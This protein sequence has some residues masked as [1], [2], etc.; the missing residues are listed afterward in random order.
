[1]TEERKQSLFLEYI[2]GTLDAE[3]MEE[4]HA[5]TEEDPSAKEEL[6]S[7]K[8]LADAAMKGDEM[9][10]FEKDRRAA[11]LIRTVTGGRTL[12]GMRA[13]EIFRYAAV[14]VVAAFLGISGAVI[15]RRPG[16]D[17]MTVVETL[18]GAATSVTLPDGTSVTLKS[19]SVLQYAPSAFDRRER[20]VMLDGEAFFKVVADPEHPF[21]VRTP[22]Q[23][24]KVL[25][26]TFNVQDFKED[27]LSTIILME[28]K[29]SLDLLDTEGA[30]VRSLEIHP[31][32]KCIY[33]KTTGRMKVEKISRGEAAQDWNSSICYFRGESLDRIASRLEQY[34]KVTIEVDPGLG[35][36]GGYSGAVSLGEGVERI[37]NLLNYDNSFKLV[38]PEDGYYL[39]KATE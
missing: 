37:L 21:I 34:F 36:E 2:D 3:G 6:F 39:L 1:M 13:R 12:A 7:L 11:D 15:L 30:S 16:N 4:L 28:G 22:H 25:G 17:S 32:E 33:D 5:L 35:K 19:A 8:E 27:S 14:A 29:V 18:P 38:M 31:G 23:A 26:T 10:P 20:T 9:S 24:V